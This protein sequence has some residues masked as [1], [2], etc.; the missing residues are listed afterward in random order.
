MLGMQGGGEQIRNGII[1]LNV[2]CLELSFGS[3]GNVNKTFSKWAVHSQYKTIMC[4]THEQS[5]STLCNPVNNLSTFNTH[6][7]SYFTSNIC[8]TLR[9]QHTA[10]KGPSVCMRPHTARPVSSRR[11]NNVRI[12]F[13]T[14]TPRKFP[15]PFPLQACSKQPPKSFQASKP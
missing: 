3:C 4:E 11:A 1:I 13:I 14:Q 6:P 9:S 8:S 10:T 15:S 2:I 5:I 7:L 12:R